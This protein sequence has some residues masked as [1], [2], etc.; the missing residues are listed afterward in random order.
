MIDIPIFTKQNSALNRYS[1][2]IETEITEEDDELS[3]DSKMNQ[4]ESPNKERLMT[5]ENN[6]N[7]TSIKASL[8]STKDHQTNYWLKIRKCNTMRNRK[9]REL[10]EQ[11]NR[12]NDLKKKLKSKEK[13]LQEKI[14]RYNDIKNTNCEMK[15]MILLKIA[16]TNS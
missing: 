11:M 16:S 9:P 15:K 1:E 7:D 10:K 5:Y 6:Y 2:F 3:T 13:I 8:N 4:Y 12:L 14:D